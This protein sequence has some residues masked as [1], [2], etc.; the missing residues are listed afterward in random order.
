MLCC[1]AQNPR[2]STGD[3]VFPASPM[4]QLALTLSLAAAALF[5]VPS[6]TL[7]Q[8]KPAGSQPQRQAGA[9][10]LDLETQLKVLTEKLGLDADQQAKLRAIFEKNGPKLKELM[11][12]SP[13]TITDADRKAMLDLA[14]AQAAEVRAVLTLAQLE[15]MKEGRSKGRSG[16]KPEAK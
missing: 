15:K 5:A 9:R 2:N 11:A 7:A 4:K 14:N 13:A 6:V 12:K 10:P 16:V 3:E 1:E 8:D